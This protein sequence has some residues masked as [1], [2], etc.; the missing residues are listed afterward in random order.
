MSTLF[1]FKNISWGNLLISTFVATIVV[2]VT[3]MISG[4]NILQALGMM[5]VGADASSGQ[6]YAA[7]GFAH[8]VTG[9]VYAL[10]YVLLF[11]TITQWNRLTKGIIFGIVTT[12]MALTLMPVMASMVSG[13]APTVNPCAPIE[14]NPCASNSRNSYNPCGIN[15]RNPCAMKSANP[16]AHQPQNSGRYQTLQMTPPE[17]SRVVKTSNPYM[18]SNPCAS[19]SSSGNVYAGAISL[20]NHIIF[21]LT[22]AF[23]VRIP[24]KEA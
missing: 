2:T 10:F 19:G 9:I 14:H 23:F 3:M 18:P 22:L 24:E 5:L 20:I 6:Q 13:G 21:G 8:L 11:A 16:C 15:N 12:T 1:N 17:S 7:G 4:T